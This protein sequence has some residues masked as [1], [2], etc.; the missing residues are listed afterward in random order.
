MAVDVSCT[1]SALFIVD[2]C[3]HVWTI[4]REALFCNEKNNEYIGDIKVQRIEV[5]AV[6][7]PSQR[8]VQKI[9]CGR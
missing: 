6:T 3:G 8:F 5:S 2:D 1:V 9:F 7:F 4:K